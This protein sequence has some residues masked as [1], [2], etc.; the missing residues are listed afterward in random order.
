MDLASRLSSLL[1][2]FMNNLKLKKVLGIFLILIGAGCIIVGAI[3]LKS[4]GKDDGSVQTPILIVDPAPSSVETTETSSIANSSSEA[5]SATPEPIASS[6]ATSPASSTSNTTSPS[7]E[8]SDSK[9]DNE[10]HE[11]GVLFEKYIVG[12][13]GS[14]YW[15]IKEWRGDK[16]VNGRYSES[17]MNPDLEMRLSFKDKEYVIAVECKWRK[18]SYEG[19]VKWSYPDQL[20][21][22]KEYARK[23]NI[24]V[25]V[26]L[27]IGGLPSSPSELYLIPLKDLSSPT[28]TLS[29][30]SKYRMISKRSFFYDSNTQ[31]FK[32]N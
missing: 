6:V 19:K 3:S 2:S 8:S 27:G 14:K 11:K 22:Y 7:S 25:F 13:F 17:N 4:S 28:V 23:N 26:A 21:R 15:T 31:D 32:R 16:G 10:N 29:E 24:P 12:R 9:D 20:K 1:I 5:S 30:I 18:S